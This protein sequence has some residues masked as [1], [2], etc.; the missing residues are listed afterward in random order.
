L[1]KRSPGTL[2]KPGKA[3]WAYYRAS[4]PLGSPGLLWVPWLRATVLPSKGNENSLKFDKNI[5]KTLISLKVDLMRELQGGQGRA[6][7]KARGI[8]E[9]HKI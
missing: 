8:R 3:I 9:M 2:G 5:D 7:R 6:R 1:Y 4:C